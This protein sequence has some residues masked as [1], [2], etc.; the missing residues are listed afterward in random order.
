MESKKIVNFFFELLHLKRVPRSGFMVLGIKDVDSVAEHVFAA[1]QIAYILGKMEGVN[2]ERAALITLFHDNGE[3]RT[4][5]LCLLQKVY[6]GDKNDAE[7]KALSE[8]AENLPVQEEIKEMYKEFEES[9]TSE[10]KVAFDADKLELAVQSKEF[11]DQG[12]KS[13]QIFIN[14]IRKS[15]KTESAKKLLDIIE[16][17]DSNSWWQEIPGIKEK[18]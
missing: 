3:A 8:Q 11:I 9:K 13:A 17:T 16:Q 14:G 7:G 18:L 10:A 15:I 6:L 12:N 2:A 4:F 5:D 1:T